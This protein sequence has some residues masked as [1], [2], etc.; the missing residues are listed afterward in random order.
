MISVASLTPRRGRTVEL[1]LLVIAVSIVMLAYA[2]VEIAAR[3]G[4]PPNLL[5]Q[6]AGLL[7]LAVVFHLVL[8]WRAS[9]ADPLLL[10]IATLLNGLG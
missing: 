4:L 8:R 10:P 6:G 2:N 3:E 5:A 1:L 7:T 9:Y